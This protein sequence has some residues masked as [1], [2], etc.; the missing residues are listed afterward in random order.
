MTIETPED[1]DPRDA[2][3]DA[4]MER[5]R[6]QPN[7]LQA[8]EPAP[9]VTPGVTETS[10]QIEG[11]GLFDDLT[12]RHTV[13]LG[14]ED[15]DAREKANAALLGE[16]GYLNEKGKKDWVDS[17]RSWA[18]WGE[19]FWSGVEE[20]IVKPRRRSLEER[21]KRQ[22]FTFDIERDADPIQ[23]WLERK[24]AANKA[25]SQRRK[26]YADLVDQ[27]KA[28]AATQG[29]ARNIAEQAGRGFLD[30]GIGGTVA[31]A[32]RLGIMGSRDSLQSS[33][34]PV[35]AIGAV[36]FIQGVGVKAVGDWISKKASELFPTDP[37]RQEEFQS[38]VG[39]G[40]GTMFA[41]MGP[42]AAAA[43][44]SRS[45]P[46]TLAALA[47]GEPELA[48]QIAAQSAAR[49]GSA[50]SATMGSLM[51]AESVA[52]EAEEAQAAGKPVT[53]DDVER[54]FL[55]ALPVGATEAVPVANWFTGAQGG[56]IRGVL[57]EAAEEGGQEFIQTLG[58]NVIAQSIYDPER[59]WDEG[60][61][62]GALVGALLG[63][64]MEGGRQGAAMPWRE[65]AEPDK[66]KLVQEA[67]NRATSRP[68]VEPLPA[69]DAAPAAPAIPAGKR[70]RTIDLDGFTPAQ[71]QNDPAE[72]EVPGP[73]IN[74]G[75]DGQVAPRIVRPYDA[76]EFDAYEF[77]EDLILNNK[78]IPAEMPDADLDQ[79]LEFALEEGQSDERYKLLAD[80]LQAVRNARVEADAQPNF[81]DQI[82]DAVA[83]QEDRRLYTRGERRYI[84]Q[85]SG[86]GK[87]DAEL[88][89]EYR[90]ML[91]DPNNDSIQAVDRANDEFA[92]R[93][94]KI[95]DRADA[96]GPSQAIE[97][98]TG[99]AA[100]V[101]EQVAEVAEQVAPG[102][103]ER[104]QS[105]TRADLVEVAKAANVLA[106]SRTKVGDIIERVVR[107][108][109]SGTLSP[110]ALSTQSADTVWGE[111][112]PER[113][114]QLRSE[115]AGRVQS[116]VNAALDALAGRATPAAP[117]ETG[118][119]SDAAYKRLVTVL[120][121]KTTRTGWAKA[122]KV[123]EKTLA[124]LLARAEKDGLVRKDSAGNYRRG[125]DIKG[126][127]KALRKGAPAAQP[128]AAAAFQ[129]G[130]PS[131]AA[132]VEA[133]A[134]VSPLPAP[135]LSVPADMR[136]EKAIGARERKLRRP[137]PPYIT[138]H[139]R[140]IERALGTPEMDAVIERL[141]S[142]EM[143]RKAEMHE[144]AAL[145]GKKVTKS[146][147]KKAAL[148]TILDRHN[149]AM[150]ARVG[151]VL[152]QEP[153]PDADSTA[154]LEDAG[155]VLEEGVS[156]LLQEIGAIGPVGEP[157]GGDRAGSGELGG[158]P[159][160]GLVDQIAG[161]DGRADA[162]RSVD[163][164][165]G[166]R[167]RPSGPIV[168]PAEVLSDEQRAEVA[169]KVEADKAA[170]DQKRRDRETLNYQIT[171]ED[172][173]GQGGPKGKIRAN[174]AAIKVLRTLEDERRGPTEA[175]KKV[176]VRY[177]GWGAFSEKMFKDY[178]QEFKKE[179]DEFRS[180]VSNDEYEA[181]RNSTRN[182]HYTSPD[183]V[184]AMWDA[185]Q[186]LGFKGG[187]AIE[188]GAGSGNF[189]GLTPSNIREATEWTA[190][191]LD[192][193]TGGIAK[194]LYQAAD[195]RVQGYQETKFPDG[196]FDLAIS[197]VPFSSNRPYDAEYKGKFVL[198]DYYFVKSLD[199]VR[200]GGIVAF[201]TSS[202]TMDK[203][204]AAARREMAKRADLVGAIRLPGGS[205]G[206]FKGNAG[207]DVT[208]DIIFLR[209]RVEGEPVGDQSWLNVEDIQTPEGPTKINSYY[210]QNPDMMLGKMR[211][212]GK[213]YGKGEPVLI[214]SSDNLDQKIMDA[215]RAGMP[216]NAMT[217]RGVTAVDLRPVDTET[218]GIKDGAYYVKG[219][220]LYRKVA[221]VGEPQSVPKAQREKIEM[222]LGLR[223]IV[224]E[225]LAI[226]GGLKEAKPERMGQLRKGLNES[227]DAFVKAHGP[228]K[229]TVVTKQNRKDGKEV[230]I[231]RFPNI[232]AFEDD[233][234][235]YKVAEVEVYDEK[236]D[237]AKKAAI[238]TQ[239]IVS[240]YIPPDVQVP[241]DALAVS[242]NEVG[243][244]DIPLIADRLGLTEAEAL[245]A[246][247]DQVYLDPVGEQY[248]T[249]S[250]Y[251]AGDVV[252]KLETARTAAETN[253]AY[254]RNVSA[255]EAVQPEPLTRADIRVSFGAPYV[256]V[257]IYE[258]YLTEVLKARRIKLRYD[259]VMAR[260]YFVEGSFPPESETTFG[261][262]RRK[263]ADLVEAALNSATITITNKDEEGKPVR[264][265][266]AE[267]EAR[268]KVDIIK[269]TFSGDPEQGIEGWLWGDY[270]RATRI[271][272]AYNNLF[273]RIVQEKH[274]GSHLT[275][276]G[277]SRAV[278]AADGSTF[279]IDLKPHRVN[280]IWKVIKQGN[281]LFNH[282]V[283]SG[284]A[285][286]LD[287]KV[288][289]PDGWKRMGDVQ[290]GDQVISADGNPTTVL[291]VYPQ[292]EKEI[293]KVVFS[294]GSST[295]CC[296]EHLWLTQTYRERSAGQRAR[297]L[298]K[299]WKSGEGKVRSL[300]DIR[301]TLVSPHLNAKNH[302]IPMVAPVA[303]NARPVPLDPYLVGVLIG[304]GCLRAREITFSTADAEILESV[305]KALPPQC[306]VR[307]RSGYDYAICYTGEISFAKRIGG[308]V[309]F[310][311]VAY[312][313]VRSHPVAVALDALG[314]RGKYA[315]EK[316][317][318][319]AY[320]NNSI[321]V[322]TE[323]LRGLMDTDGT[324]DGKGYGVSFCTSSPGLA[325]DVA[326]L[327]QSLGGIVGRSTKRI[328]GYRDATILSV[329]LPPEIN[330][331][332][333]SRKAG[334]V[335]P[336]S[337]YIPARYIVDVVAVGTKP[338][339]CIAVSN[340]SHLYVTDDFVVTHNT[341]TSIMASM[342]MKRLG[343]IQRPMF[344]VP[345][346]MLNQ[347]STEFYQAYPNAKLLIATK[348]QMS[349]KNRKRFA[350]RIAADTWDGIIIT[351]SSFGKMGLS[352][353][354]YQDYYKEQMEELELSMRQA[355]SEGNDSAVSD[356]M[357]KWDK[358]NE[359]LGG[360]TDAVPDGIDVKKKKKRAPT[361]KE[362]EGKKDA[363]K[364]KLKK[365]VAEED[366]DDGVTF[367]ETGID[368]LFVDEAHLFKSLPFSTLH[369]RIKGIGGTTSKRAVDLFLKMRHIEKSRPGRSAV[370][371]TGTPVSNTMAELYTMQRYLQGPTLKKFGIDKFDA[372]AGTFGKIVVKS[373]LASNSRD[374]KDTESFSEFVN[375]PE[376][377]TIA[378][379]MMDT[380]TAEMLKL[381]RPELKGGKLDVVQ[382]QLS[383]DEEGAINELIDK[384][385]KR[386]KDEPF[387]PLF[388]AGIQLATDMRLV[389]PS[390]P[391]NTNGKI[392]KAVDNIFSIWEEGNADPAA[393]NKGQLVFLD[394]GVPGS[395]GKAKATIGASNETEAGPQDDAESAL[396]QIRREIAEEAGQVEEGEEIEV[397]DDQV[398]VE[399]L[400]RGKF[401]LYQDIKD[402]LIAKGVP[403]EQ[404][405]F[406]HDAKNDDQ[407]AKMFEKMR[408]GDIRVMIG[409]TGKMGVGTNVQKLLYAMHHLDAPWRPA[410]LEQRD[411]R[412]LRQGNK[413]KEVRIFRYITVKSFDAYRW[414]LLDRKSQ[415]IGQLYAGAAGVRHMEDITPPL[416]EAA[417]LKAAA[418]GNPLIIERAELEREV[419]KLEVAE[420]THYK[421]QKSAAENVKRLQDK[422]A[423]L[424]AFNVQYEQDVPRVEDLR[425]D[426][427]KVK[428]DTT[429]KPTVVDDRKKAGEF[430]KRYVLG[431]GQQWY[432]TI[433]DLG[434]I[435]S[436]AMRAEIKKT[437]N[438]VEVM[439]MIEG[440]AKYQA[441]QPFVVG[442]DADP[443]QVIQRWVRLVTGVPAYA[444]KV[445]A[446]IA[447]DEDTLPKMQEAAQPKPFPQTDKLVEKRKRLETVITEL[448]RKPEA[449]PSIAQGPP[450]DKPVT[451]VF[452][453]SFNPIHVGHEIAIRNAAKF[454]EDK[455]Y[456]VAR[457]IIAPS[458]EK[459]LKD[460]L[461]E[462]AYSL[463]DRA[464]M[465]RLQ[466]GNDPAFPVS[467][468]PALE[469]QA[470]E[471]KAKRTHL[472]NWAKTQFPDDTIAA[473][474][475]ADAAP[476]QPPMFPSVYQG[477][478]GTS[479]EGYYYVAMPRDEGDGMSSST[480]RKALSEGK[481]VP[482]G[483]MT[484]EA[485][486]YLRDMIAAQPD[487]VAAPAAAPAAEIEDPDAPNFSLPEPPRTLPDGHPLLLPHW[488]DEKT[489]P[490]EFFDRS[491]E[492]EALRAKIIEDRFAGKK[493]AAPGT[494]VAYVMGGGGAS[495]KG[496]V[497]KG[498]R[499]AG[500]I[501]EDFVELD[502]DSFKTGDPKKGW[503]G[504]P[505]YWQIDAEGDSRAAK[506]THEESSMLNK[507]AVD[508]GIK[509]GYDL[510]LDQTLGNPD[511]GRKVIKMLQDAGYEVRLIGVTVAP[512]TAV[513]RAVARAKGPERRYVP[514]DHLLLAHKGFS[515]GFESYA[516]MAD[517][518][519]LIDTDV[520]YGA[521]ALLVAEKKPGE[522][523][524]ILGEQ[525]YI[526]FGRKADV[527]GQE[528]T[529][530]DLR[531]TQGRVQEKRETRALAPSYIARELAGR[532][533]GAKGRRSKTGPQDGSSV[534]G[535]GLTPPK[536][537]D[538]VAWLRDIFMRYGVDPDA[539]GKGDANSLE[540]AV[541]EIQDGEI[542]LIVR[543]GKLVR[544]GVVAAI[545]VVAD[546]P[547]GV[548]MRLVE[549]RQEMADG[550]VRRRDLPQ[551]LA[552]KMLP[553]EDPAQ[554]I[555]R[556]LSEELGIKSFRMLGA[557]KPETAAPFES[558]RY[559]GL[560]SEYT[561]NNATVALD[562][563]DF[564]MEYKEVQKDKTNVF[565]WR[566]AGASPVGG[567]VMMSLRQ[568]GSSQ[569]EGWF[570]FTNALKYRI[571][572][573]RIIQGEF[574]VETRPGNGTI[575]YTVHRGAARKS[576]V[577]TGAMVA[578]DETQIGRFYLRTDA[579]PEGFAVSV[580]NMAV[581]PEYQGRG[582][583]T[584]VFNMI[585]ADI[586]TTGVKLVPPALETLSPDG[587][588]FW[589]ARDPEALANRDRMERD[590]Y[591]GGD[592]AARIG[593]NA[594]GVA[595]TPAFDA[596]R[597]EFEAELLR[598]AKRI[599]DKG[600]QVEVQNRIQIG[601]YELNGYYDSGRKL[602][603]IALES[604]LDNAL[605]TIRHEEIHAL[606]DL[607]LLSD[608]EWKLLTEAAN[609]ARVRA[610]IGQDK[611][612]EYRESYAA[613]VAKTMLT[614][615]GFVD[616]VQLP[617]A[618]VEAKLVEMFGFDPSNRVASL[619]SLNLWDE[620]ILQDL[621]DE[622]AVAVLVSERMGGASY[623]STVDGIVDQIAQ[624]IERLT[625]A[626]RGLG[627]KTVEDVFRAIDEGTIGKRDPAF[628]GMGGTFV[629]K[630]LMYAIRAFHGSP[631]SFDRFSL[632]KIGTGEGAQAYGHGL[633]FADS[634]DVARSYRDAGVKTFTDQESYDAY[635]KA[636]LAWD[637]KGDSPKAPGQDGRM[638]EVN[639]KANPEDF[640]DWDKPLGQQSEKVRQAIEPLYPRTLE[641]VN[642]MLQANGKPPLEA[643]FSDKASAFYG[644]LDRILGGVSRG[645]ISANAATQALREAGIPGIRYLDGMS[646]G[647]GEGSYNY[648]IFDEDLIEITAIDGQ[649]VE[650]EE[651]AEI[652]GAAQEAE[653]QPGGM[654]DTAMMSIADGSDP[655]N[656]LP[657]GYVDALNRR[658]EG[659]GRAPDGVAP[660]PDN[661]LMSLT[662][663]GNYQ[664]LGIGTN[665]QFPNNDTQA[666][667]KGL[668]D[669]VADAVTALGLEN[670]VRQGRLDP[671]MKRAA[672]KMGG[673][674][675]GQTSRT[676]GVVRLALKNDLATLAHEGGHALEIR[677]SV[678]DDLNAIK[679]QFAEDLTV[680]P[681]PNAPAP[682]FP[683]TGFSGIEMDQDSI[684]LAI[685]SVDA[686]RQM[687]VLAAELGALKSRARSRQEEARFQQIKPMYEQF[688]NIAGGNRETLVRRF[689]ADRAD[690][691]LTDLM[692]VDRV[693]AP[694]YAATRFSKSGQ[695]APRVVIPPTDVEMSE[696][697]AEWFR[698]YLTNP[699]QA[700]ALSRGFFDSFEDMLDSTEPEML[701]RFQLI[702]QEI[703]ALAKAAPVSAVRARVQSTVQPGL[704]ESIRL[705][706][707]DAAD[708]ARIAAETARRTG[709]GSEIGSAMSAFSA[710]IWRPMG[711][712][713]Y[714][715]YH[716]SFDA[717]HPM[718]KAVQFLIDKAVEN[719]GTKLGPNE[720]AV[721]KAL[722]DP[723]KLWRLAEHSKT[724]ATAALQFGIV[725]KGQID[726]SGPSYWDALTEA[727]GGS[728]R[729]QWNDDMA[730]MFG[731]YLI[732]KRMLAEFARYDRGELE[733]IPDTI[734]TR[735]VWQ[736]STAQLEKEN[737]QFKRAAQTMYRFGQELLKYKFENG[738]LT[739]EQYAE[740]S[741]RVDYTPLNRIMDAGTPSMLGA[742]GNV[743]KRRLIYRF[744]GSTRDFIN[745]LETIAQDMF[746]TQQRVEMNR[747]IGAMDRMA[748]AA[749]PGGG[750][751]AERIPAKTMQAT[752]IRV[753]DV[754]SLAQPLR[755]ALAR[756]GMDRA[757]RD[758]LLADAQ[759]EM[760]DS[761]RLTAMQSGLSIDDQQMLLDTIDLLFDG[762]ASK[763][764]FKATDI[765]EGGEPIVYLWEGGQRI[766][767]RMGD[768][769]IAQD[770]FEGF[771]AFGSS[772]ANPIVDMAALGTQA[773][774]AG[775]T[776]APSYVLVNYLRDQLS[777][778]VLSENFIPFVTGA[779]GLKSVLTNDVSAKRYGAFAGLMGGID[780]QL[781]DE[782]A[783]KHDVLTLRRRGFFAV[784]AKSGIG[785]VWQRTLKAMEIT[786]AGTR[787]GHFEAAFNRAKA[788]GM[789]DEEAA[790]EAAYAAHDV[791]DFSRRGSKTME[792]SRIVAFLN[793]A[794]QGIDSTRR[795]LS[796]ERD[797]FTNY[798]DLITPYVKAANGMP[799][800]VAEK[801]AIPSSAKVVGKMM[802]LGM[803][804]LAL[805][806]LYK[807]DEEYEEFNDYMKA[808]HWFF[809]LG[810]TW[811]RFPKPFDLAIFSQMFEGAFDRFVKEDPRA[812]EKFM[813][814]LKHTMVPPHEINVANLYYEMATG[815]DTFRNREIV[816]MELS[817]LPP[818]LQFGAYTSEMG[819]MIGSLTGMSPQK[820]DHV[821]SG[822]LGTIGRDIQTISDTALP[823]ANEAL[824]GAIP[825]V[826]DKPRADKSFEDM[827]IV[828]RFTRRAG[829]GSLSAET[830]WKQMKMSGGEY[831]S[832]AEGY[833]ALRNSGRGGEAR[834]LLANVS[835]DQRAYAILEV[836][837]SEKEQD[838]NPLNRAK[839]VMSAM[840][841][842]R[843]E[844]VLGRL[845]KGNMTS[846]EVYK[847]GDDAEEIIL[848]PSKQKI[849]NEI[850]EDLSMREARNALVAVGLPGWA[851]KE[852]MPTDGLLKELEAA[853][854]EVAEEL[855]LRLTKGRN[856]V[857]SFEG[858]REV[859][860][861]ARDRLLAQGPEA[862][863]SDLVS[864]AKFYE[865]STGGGMMRLGGPVDTNPTM[866]VSDDLAADLEFSAAG[867]PYLPEP[868]EDDE[869]GWMGAV[870]EEREAFSPSVP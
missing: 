721:V 725:H 622:E 459:L 271:E 259:D 365:L 618:D 203:K 285:Q 597:E 452:A 332:R 127:I 683:Q 830:F 739:Q 485:E 16:W 513:K 89:A 774:R 571:I 101:I 584:A 305:K 54:A 536:D 507:R 803:V 714:G 83:P 346:H 70:T 773:L 775:I 108:Y 414:Q 244:V 457:T 649:P 596:K 175:E 144:L 298:G 234:D 602:I 594:P 484:P 431:A 227:Y 331:F 685:A 209:K 408:S 94:Q 363:A 379:S 809:K 33:I 432:K 288:L 191:E 841:G 456:T 702:Q 307:Y 387:L 219:K 10:R 640:L 66:P 796:G 395:K 63:G 791:I 226:Q 384:M 400:L 342:E 475:G 297:K 291:G 62:T 653:Q 628:E 765:S 11:T 394:M 730:E 222:F 197:N 132:P 468:E 506:V 402:K 334:R 393:P 695:P 615:R 706:L 385:E 52:R 420:R 55:F 519:I 208:T 255:L 508:R 559:P 303:L 435:S 373:E 708:A 173:I 543:D 354:A 743:N 835:D 147:T 58:N 149:D 660:L 340:P 88:V 687:R 547:G 794:L 159:D 325:E 135:T 199:K 46:R 749:G 4:I 41:F 858:V 133:A 700:Q 500:L 116:A 274:D 278:T 205:Q 317:V 383:P 866:E 73:E 403:K 154:V 473:V 367:E 189:I 391:F 838:I 815:I 550:R 742:G 206:A 428:L 311:G 231:K 781:I 323:V 478:P 156:Q 560:M 746:A 635:K 258:Q 312:E 482:D 816:P 273:N 136:I 705:G 162:A 667:E 409:S 738:F 716:A 723:Y 425:G 778:W 669:V 682:M 276:P 249:S 681:A 718:K 115:S 240:A 91:A 776:K 836:E 300:A 580:Q 529:L 69:E 449:D 735:D 26:F 676:T 664:P 275:F 535:Q 810:D 177:T 783:N 179:R 22:G 348:D 755:G 107:R 832:A 411:G 673:D 121:G 48:A 328:A 868:D 831:T 410:D 670:M 295:E 266:E 826:S 788:D 87:T 593:V 545:E 856:K 299:N 553:G 501:D 95:R 530:N 377:M 157:S 324:V 557:I 326:Y 825:G 561:T 489:D 772:D 167:D 375:M 211:L 585:E 169:A 759:N 210:A 193:L 799:L 551:S 290:V 182:A 253:P 296:D 795:G 592:I 238:F 36:Q 609:K 636:M 194:N 350:A 492:R 719:S 514:L 72:R 504:I 163:P 857:Y 164:T 454:M 630:G 51:N 388:T 2:E 310:R 114:K 860:P 215:V 85:E 176:L 629:P 859:W 537:S 627:F 67:R 650:A 237:T 851:Q 353:G 407:K 230:I 675:M 358:F 528:N 780:A 563:A 150:A 728:K 96:R 166:A 818:E 540:K 195:V 42:S 424:K 430:V 483:M 573:S 844:M 93:R 642:K 250:E 510:V 511:K 626:L 824:G 632:D 709:A 239:D 829:R 241:A 86:S 256:P 287:A 771:Q 82:A 539:Y 401:N 292:G 637:G 29:T 75:P 812:G 688:Q 265:G 698:I 34:K 828:S 565:T 591:F 672:R 436:F 202:G 499:E 623:G 870:G 521:D 50:V 412:I 600:V 863:L 257:E 502:P 509:G 134:P 568:P 849:V 469:L 613:K 174:I 787:F 39:N 187:R 282:A 744:Q 574:R 590:V 370:F 712:R 27:G 141:Q 621:L 286:P 680:P 171:I 77:T 1:Y 53:D 558:P 566:Y 8:E 20:N 56:F 556:A 349:A 842:I 438:G 137:L 808:T 59:K 603:K 646:R 769:E 23:G 301:S 364:E 587:K 369:T 104:L 7:V 572:P 785:Q 359:E 643:D 396:E 327:V 338:A 720:R 847:A 418:T 447:R 656:P 105:L 318:P 45:G 745:P 19:G 852:I 341:W 533:G 684:G 198:H 261:T 404:I 421:T 262:N 854:P 577:V 713:L 861:E 644:N 595:T 124:T 541:K 544:Q 748:R 762:E 399:A 357:R 232:S 439:P 663:W 527:N 155:R 263:V 280:A 654:F 313:A 236:T 14:A 617:W 579:T 74:V 188:P 458:P 24:I 631:H 648:V 679:T 267:A 588:A 111:P 18:E 490:P 575:T 223:D 60:A 805:S 764:I 633:Y 406:I 128:R 120:A 678:R 214:G 472:A 279:T 315:H 479:H 337:K 470:M 797:S 757:D 339:Q 12:A 9:L 289:T 246:L 864:D 97:A 269:D 392:A 415:F 281:T 372:W 693:T 752:R 224:N 71:L 668:S 158:G 319:E 846:K 306:E 486:A 43:L 161:G 865:P 129:A 641:P 302:S 333:L 768:N 612:V 212:V 651:K 747:V 218:D 118:E 820:V 634:E 862:D 308:N 531:R 534:S 433:V 697:F 476:G 833:K 248:R 837:F 37:A 576:R 434:E 817:K 662:K 520:T 314:M 243:R 229:K 343:M 696:G 460:K 355:Q 192:P 853:A 727:F 578:D 488:G 441:D 125:K 130:Q 397:D 371:M 283:G 252:G 699:K 639:I 320:L 445:S 142:D 659:L 548:R 704:I 181:A 732:G 722:H 64:S 376:L 233:P 843:K 361:I 183:V 790:F 736:K 821:V 638:Y 309:G 661:I 437:L 38:A 329:T 793:A 770:I 277:L 100:P 201:I 751:I 834:D 32:G 503:G 451:L 498:L 351:H 689:G 270:T 555:N 405:A 589:E 272:A 782:S 79:A 40:V 715:F 474:T 153:E 455:G 378:G 655:S 65:K 84:A 848:P 461:G 619:Q 703:D 49:T 148:Q 213:M 57:R 3:Y 170:A 497:L 186:Y 625:N 665:P 494:Q 413:N 690:A 608:G 753:A 140:D 448:N 106:D 480:I 789:S 761:M 168:G 184:N 146:A 845:Y 80:E 807:D 767:I 763:T 549:D 35:Q 798:R 677:A 607:G 260:W 784:P 599:K 569:V 122:T 61:W 245:A 606:R 390:A 792:V 381:P 380:Q 813:Q 542:N 254:A 692:P 360:D 604:G 344:V 304:D 382:A 172:K 217:E 446:D 740:Y 840:S 532:L 204:N 674:M 368:F 335:K 822:L 336:K 30:A 225:M 583:A 419:K 729:G 6:S 235:A 652:L 487:L 477:D 707:S 711:D 518:A 139:A 464:E 440:T 102:I 741:N 321:E 814:S 47:A 352:K 356:M 81:I 471:G 505:E 196:F 567:D 614:R 731:S 710:E 21:A 802:V 581:D 416:P 467:I 242:L 131:A 110:S 450:K 362:K 417:E 496:T 463:E 251:L 228:I 850:L 145:V 429:G 31:G 68:D 221:G 178:D 109:E 694:S 220:D 801:K 44:L 620:A 92:A 117:A 112:N 756:T 750:A 17:T 647:A 869:D 423:S 766:P 611:L 586:E 13:D 316:R 522:T 347:F 453:G 180:L 284:K 294:D 165:D 701:T 389:D 491:P 152:E 190:V 786:E 605:T 691:I 524:A 523:L 546:M 777:T 733:N 724:H 867:R 734:I 624:F 598:I 28:P 126:A 466:F 143:I 601:K 5:A 806:M 76:P 819:R 855:A 823:A 570:Q 247:G 98:L 207:T 185:M 804:G 616:L 526:E 426:A 737:P 562:A 800:S 516:E 465:I 726:P 582:I 512:E 103:T 113:I 564:K 657:P 666:P 779:R 760:R 422:V 78:P 827:A 538:P 160:S 268:A 442:E 839:Q 811:Y 515:E 264:D 345:N 686:E 25:Q 398:E 444:A 443:G 481:P 90:E 138:G 493:P 374:Y 645:E 293:F 119:P 427:F 151:A 517:Y 99:R 671:A 658:I 386:E 552:E 15:D 330:P 754:A 200:P 717:R 216:E 525:A 758:S 462:R 554:V 495:G 123:S 366:K 610:D 322:R